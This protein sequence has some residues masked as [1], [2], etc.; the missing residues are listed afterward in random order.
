MSGKKQGSGTKKNDLDVMESLLG[1]GGQFNE[2]MP[3]QTKVRRNPINDI[4]INVDTEKPEDVIR[5]LVEMVRKMNNE[6]QELKLH[7]EG[8]YCTSAEFN[9]SYDTMDK[10]IDELTQRFDTFEIEHE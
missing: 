7:A 3:Q 2:P 8:T 4:G 10:R 1:L 6:I 5:K 9:R